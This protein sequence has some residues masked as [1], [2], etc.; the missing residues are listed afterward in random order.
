M[1]HFTS[2]VAGL[3]AAAAII[4]WTAGT[5]LAAE[6]YNPKMSEGAKRVEYKAD[7]FK[8][9][10]A[11]EDLDYDI[12]AQLAIYGGKSEVTAPRPLFELGQPQYVSGQLSEPSYVFGR[13]NPTQFAI[14]AFGD[15][16]TAIAFNDNANDEVAQ[17]ATRLN[18]DIDFKITSTERLHAFIR[19]IDTGNQFTRCEFAGGDSEDQCNLELQPNIETLFFEGD[20]GAI[21]AGFTGEYYKGDYPFAVGLVPIFYQNGIWVNDAVLGAAYAIPAQNS[22]ALDISNME[23][24]FFA[25][26]DNVENDGILDA[27][28]AVADK[29]ANVYGANAFIEML[30]GYIEAGV[31]YI[32]VDEDK[33][34]DQNLWSAGLSWSA[35]YHD[36]LS[37]SV[38]GI[39]SRQNRE[40]GGQDLGNGMAFLLET[41]YM[42]HKPY[43]LL[44][45]AN[46]FVGFGRPQSL[47][48]ANGILINTGINFE[49]D[50]LTGFPFLDDTAADTFGGAVGLQYLF[51]LDQQLVVEAATV[52]THGNDANI[53]GDQYAL[54]VRWQLPVSQA[55]ILR[56]DAMYG[57]NTE[58]DDLAGIRFEVRRKF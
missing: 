26:F 37:Y 19:P 1:R 55:W 49:T 54:G 38:R 10:P 51:N 2:K 33:L 56:A 5:S 39:F 9:M 58:N 18:I 11:Y 45:Y 28:G 41:S 40:D 8:P 12:E 14:Q 16:R 3:T 43:T 29:N 24:S 31:G 34:G 21:A 32:D 50:G 6:D 57:I 47:I 46:F 7:A 48:N 27:G 30:Q 20:L 25:G 36:I 13:L 53:Q 52:Q 35:R 44:P 4:A 22:P 23:F 15:W 17:I 42:T